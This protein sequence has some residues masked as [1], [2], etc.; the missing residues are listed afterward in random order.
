MKLKSFTVAAAR[1]SAA[2]FEKKKNPAFYRKP[3][4]SFGIV[5]ALLCAAQVNAAKIRVVATLTD[6]ADLTRKSAAITLTSSALRPAS[7]TRTACR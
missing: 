7:K 4:R 5:L 6:L 3:L 1:Q 2:N